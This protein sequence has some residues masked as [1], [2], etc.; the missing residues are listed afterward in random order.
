MNTFSMRYYPK[1]VLRVVRSLSVNFSVLGNFFVFRI[2]KVFHFGK[3]EFECKDTNLSIN[4]HNI[5]RKITAK[6]C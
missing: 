1:N 3:S 4:N 6:L 2:G 5:K